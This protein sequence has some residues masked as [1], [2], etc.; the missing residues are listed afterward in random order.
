MYVYTCTCMYTCTCIHVYTYKYIYIYI[1]TLL[2]CVYLVWLSLLMLCVYICL[3][4]FVWCYL[5]SSESSGHASVG[6]SDARREKREFQRCAIFGNNVSCIPF[7]TDMCLPYGVRWR[8]GR[9]KRC[10]SR[11]CFKTR[12]CFQHLCLPFRPLPYLGWPMTCGNSTGP[13]DRNSPRLPPALLPFQKQ[14]P[15]YYTISYHSIL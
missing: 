1:Y 8:Y 6:I 2:S 11:S 9:L 3:G 14:S 4:S 7:A 15:E 5:V 13:H 12:L 10:R